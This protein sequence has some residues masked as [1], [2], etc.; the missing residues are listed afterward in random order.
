MG[1]AAAGSSLAHRLGLGVRPC[2]MGVINATPDSLW[3]DSRLAQPEAAARAARDMVAAGAAMVALG[4]VSTPPGAVDGPTELARLLP[5]LRAVRASVAV[6]LS[7]DTGRAEVVRAAI[8]LGA[9]VINAVGALDD[10]GFPAAVAETGAPVIAVATALVAPE[11]DVLEAV[12]QEIEAAVARLVAAGVETG[13]IWADPGF[14]FG[15]SVAQNLQLVRGIP[16]LRA[17][18]RRPLCLGPARRGG[19]GHLLGSRSV[20]DRRPG[21]LAVVALAAAYGA[22]ILRVHDVAAAADA[23]RIGRA[24]GAPAPAPSLGTVSIR[25][26]RLAG[27]HGVL[28]PEHT[29]PQPF[30]VDIDLELDL[31]AAAGSDRLTDTVDY[32]RAA[33]VAAEVVRGPHH[34]LLESLAGEIARGLAE[35]FPGLRG[36]AVTVHKPEAPVGLPFGDVCVRLPLGVRGAAATQ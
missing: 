13:R 21:A 18:L 10:P 1:G 15:K 26:L 7:V 19:L 27:T 16:W 6:P 8:A 30:T 23:A 2:V 28:P 33:E 14:G 11:G 29:R 12:A 31:A 5:V 9:E 32:A 22:D 24:C 36:G 4:A 25:G 20:R 3:E 34:D 35:T 17:R